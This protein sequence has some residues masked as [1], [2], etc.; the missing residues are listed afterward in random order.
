MKEALLIPLG[1]VV[2]LTLWEFRGSIA[3]LVAI[4]IEAWREKARCE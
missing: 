4:A 1:M 3:D 2:F